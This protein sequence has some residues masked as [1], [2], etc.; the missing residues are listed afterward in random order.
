MK[1]VSIIILFLAVLSMTFCD[2]S[3]RRVSRR[4]SRKANLDIKG[5][6]T[7]LQGHAK[8]FLKKFGNAVK[9]G[10]KWGWENRKEVFDTLEKALEFAKSLEK[11]I[12]KSLKRLA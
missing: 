4:A 12:N 1:F 7:S 10:A 5:M 2:R 11:T 8:N 3:S 9:K 6:L